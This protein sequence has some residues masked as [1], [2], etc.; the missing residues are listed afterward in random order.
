MCPKVLNEMNYE[1]IFVPL[2]DILFF[3]RAIMAKSYHGAARGQY[4]SVLVVNDCRADGI[5]ERK[6]TIILDHHGALF[7][8]AE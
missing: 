6:G 8:V 2:S 4:D 1:A 5:N 7:C 3:Q